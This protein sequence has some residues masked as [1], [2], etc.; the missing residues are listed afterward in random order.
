MAEKKAHLV[1][2]YDEGW[3]EVSSFGGQGIEDGQLRWPTSATVTPEGNLLVTD[4]GNN[5]ICQFSMNGDFLGHVLTNKD[6]IKSPMDIAFKSPYLAITENNNKNYCA[7]K[8]FE[9]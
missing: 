8:I 1:R 9:I 3:N 4:W 7:I 6:G 5:R 2:V